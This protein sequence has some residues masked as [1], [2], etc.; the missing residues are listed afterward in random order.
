MRKYLYI[1]MISFLW[2]S[3]TDAVS[4]FYNGEKAEASVYEITIGKDTVFNIF[5][6]LSARGENEEDLTGEI[7]LVSG[8]LDTTVAGRYCL[9][10]RIDYRRTV[11]EIGIIVYVRDDPVYPTSGLPVI[12]LEGENPLSVPLSVDVF[13]DPGASVI[14]SNGRRMPDEYLS[15]NVCFF[16]SAMNRF[17][18]TGGIPMSGPGVY[19]I[20]YNGFDYSGKAAKTVTRF[21]FY[22]NSSTRRVAITLNRYPTGELVDP[23]VSVTAGTLCIE[24]GAGKV[25]RECGGSVSFIENGSVVRTETWSDDIG[26]IPGLRRTEIPSFAVP[27][28]HSVY[29]WFSEDGSVGSVEA[30]IERPLLLVDRQ[31]PVL[32]LGNQNANAPAVTPES[33]EEALRLSEEDS[34]SLNAGQNFTEPVSAAGLFP[35]IEDN[36]EKDL[37]WSRVQT[38]FFRYNGTKNSI[39]SISAFPDPSARR[40][41]IYFIRY[42]AADR[43]GNLRVCWRKILMKSGSPAN[44]RFCYGDKETK[45]VVY[46]Y[47]SNSGETSFLPDVY[48]TDGS[49]NRL[50]ESEYRIDIGGVGSGGAAVSV[51]YSGGE[52]LEKRLSEAGLIDLKT[53]GQYSLD[54]TITYDGLKTVVKRYV[55]VFN[56][57]G[58]S[59]LSETSNDNLS[60]AKYTLRWQNT[61]K[62]KGYSNTMFLYRSNHRSNGVWE[63]VGTVN[64]NEYISVPYGI[65]FYRLVPARVGDEGEVSARPEDAPESVMIQLCRPFPAV[66]GF[67]ASNRTYTDRIELQWSVCD[68]AD[69][70]RV[71]CGRDSSSFPL[72]DDKLLAEIRNGNTYTVRESASFSAAYTWYFQIQAVAEKSLHGWKTVSTDTKGNL[73]VSTDTA[74]A[75]GMRELTDSEWLREVLIEIGALQSRFNLGDGSLDAGGKFYIDG[76]SSG[77]FYY[78]IRNESWPEND[79]LTKNRSTLL[80]YFHFNNDGR[81][82]KLSGGIAY[83]YLFTKSKNDYYVGITAKADSALYPD[84]LKRQAPLTVSGDYPGTVDIHGLL[85]DCWNRACSHS[86]TT[87]KNCVGESLSYRGNRWLGNC[88][89]RSSVGHGCPSYRFSESAWRNVLGFYENGRVTFTHRGQ[90]F[91]YTRDGGPEKTHAAFRVP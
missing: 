4:F 36:C 49:G 23:N 46:G 70:Y 71:Y 5:S 34:F 32:T 84:G 81:R 25:Y 27:G 44:I 72:S 22:G 90:M 87:V 24:A 21:V 74:K 64:E 30:F 7:E 58:I 31:A 51:P 15:K 62:E 8:Y 41:D 13:T 45:T 39:E 67:Q 66:G 83:L 85:D 77:A 69:Y 48:G 75:K 40:G 16:D 91:L 28:R 29:Y 68:N 61:Q 35:K 26:V 33:W 38:S 88:D 37:L 11:K 57:D 56:Y 59:V 54:Y 10:Y 20:D 63:R 80:D 89:G 79:W 52:D 14:D 2:I 19:R 60:Q 78:R 17:T 50:P 3:C 6:F 42:S 82:L 86:D 1:A 47:Y 18:D 53:P 55:T 12:E 73:I 65:S 9:E 76:G 43:S